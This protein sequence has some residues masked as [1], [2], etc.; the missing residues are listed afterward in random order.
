MEFIEGIDCDIKDV[1]LVAKAVQTLISLEAPPKAT[2]GQVCGGTRSIVHSFFPERF[3]NVEYK[4]DWDS[5]D[6]IHKA[7]VFNGS[8][9]NSKLR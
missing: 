6:H 7:S 2:L 5:Y 9:R 4:S 8:L 1:E 3:P